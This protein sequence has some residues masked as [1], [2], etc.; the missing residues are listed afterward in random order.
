MEQQEISK[1]N[2][3]KRIG[4]VEKVLVEDMSFDGKY[5]VGRTKQDVPDIDGLIYIKNNDKELMNQFVT[6]KIVDVKE[7]DLIGKLI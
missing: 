6:A 2:L 4:N 3:L 5:F 7:Y 1:Q